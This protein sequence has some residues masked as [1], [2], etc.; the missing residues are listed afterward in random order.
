MA[1]RIG[2]GFWWFFGPWLDPQISGILRVSQ[3][4]LGWHLRRDRGGRSGRSGRCATTGTTGG[5]AAD[6]GHR[7]GRLHLA[8][9]SHSPLFFALKPP[10]QNIIKYHTLYI[11]I[12]IIIYMFAC[13]ILM[14]I[15]IPFICVLR[16]GCHTLWIVEVT[17]SFGSPRLVI[18]QLDV[19]LQHLRRAANVCFI[20][21]YVLVY[22]TNRQVWLFCF[23]VVWS[24]LSSLFSCP[25]MAT[26][27]DWCR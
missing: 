20:L 3:V 5:V 22:S 17:S 24:L 15:G 18:C 12:S 13:G 4:G 6:G 25:Y 21:M 10:V 8:L 27:L 19:L 23:K 9:P 2:D 7:P 16:H 26:C 1:G 14:Y 11:Y